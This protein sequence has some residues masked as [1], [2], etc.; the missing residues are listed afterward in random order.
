VKEIKTNKKRAQWQGEGI[1]KERMRV[2]IV[3][4]F[5]IHR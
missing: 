4:V 5:G 3:D 1:R 2:N